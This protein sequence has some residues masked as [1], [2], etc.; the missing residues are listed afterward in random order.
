M[1]SYSKNREMFV[2]WPQHFTFRWSLTIII[3]TIVATG[4]F[5]YHTPHQRIA[6]TPV[7]APQRFKH[8]RLIDKDNQE[9]AAD[10]VIKKHEYD[11]ERE[12][13]VA[14][15]EEAL[16]QGHKYILSMEFTGFLNDN[17]RGFYRSTYRDAA[18]NLKFLA[19]TQFQATDARRAFP[20]FDEPGLKATFE[21]YLA[22]EANMTSISNMPINN[23]FPVEGQEGWLWDQFQVSVPMSTYL[24]AFVVSDFAHLNA[25]DIDHIQFRV[26][27]REEALTQAQYALRVGP[28]ILTHFEDYFNQPYPL[29]KQ[30]MIAIPDFSAGAMEN[31]GLITYRETTLL[32]DPDESS[33][34]NQY[35]VALTVAHEL[36]HQWFG[37]IVTPKWWTD[38][39][40]NEGF[41]AF[42]QYIG[43]D[44]I[45]PSWKVIELFVINK[46]QSVLTL[47]SLEASHKI[48]VRVG[49]P[50]EI[51]QIFDGISY[52]KGASIIRMMN[53]FLTEDTFRKGLSTYLN[54][55]K[56][57]NA[58]QDDLWEHLTQ[59][60]HQDGTLPLDLTV[61]TIMD[62]W[63][64][65]MGYPVIT[66]ERSPDGT[67]ASVSQERFLMVAK[68]NSNNSEE[69]KWWVPLTYTG[70]DDPNFNE[71]RAKVWMKDTETLITIQSLPTKDHWVIFNLQETGFYR[72]NYDN[73][74]W[75]LLIQQLLTDHTVITTINRAQIIDD[76]MNLARAGQV[77]YG[78]ALGL[79]SYMV[80]E[81]EYVPWRAAINNLAYLTSM[82]QRTGAYGGLQNYMLK[83]VVQLYDTLGL[84]NSVNDHLLE[85]YKR[86]MA[87]S[88]ACSL[89]H[90]QCLDNV[91]SLYRQ[92]MTNPDN[93]TIISPSLKSVVYCHALAAGET[94][95]W[96]FAWNQYLKSNLANEK[97]T[98]LRAMGCT[99]H[100]WLLSR[101]LEMAFDP[102]SGIRRQDSKL[103]FASVAYNDVGR[104]LAWT[105]LRDNFKMIYNYFGSRAPSSLITS[106]THGFNTRQ[107]LKEVMTFVDEYRTDLKSASRKVEQKIETIKNNINWMDANYMT[108][109]QWLEQ[110][111]Y[112]VKLQNVWNNNTLSI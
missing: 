97:R 24:V 32:Y 11:N 76:A 57:G 66:V 96:V 36:A 78:V 1:A 75:N 112:S 101:Y 18:G 46:L 60:A 51:S 30:D 42:V 28:A 49:H 43:M 15:L 19:V 104:P 62:T 99:R 9:G 13:Y 68:P 108:I 39:W 59:A 61:K 111:G 21:V 53:H 74:N 48:S 16:Q 91:L 81:T 95:E 103:V 65:Q 26:W 47:D 23:T 100:L 84:D 107:H 92:W 102:N 56:Y 83:M 85:Q 79:Y 25:T 41:A 40:L 77:S 106:A 45:E 5:V 14:H 2:K 73:H 12:F 93:N 29:P 86:T 22:R 80:N 109:N 8:H 3:S 89:R 37:N 6:G 94:E 52:N 88:W 50:S 55:F 69:Y 58:E 98:L 17:L 35:G 72:V 27:A 31:W 70:G 38:L 64:L 34:S 110:N 71:T 105:F 33:P 82:F 67:S 63:T 87:V 90:K 4:I 7:E 54:T 20:C 10:L 44:H